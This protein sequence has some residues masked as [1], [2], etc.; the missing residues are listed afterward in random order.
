M[1]SSRE[2]MV[3]TTVTIPLALKKKIAENNVNLSKLVRDF[4]ANTIDDE[5]ST[6][7]TEAVLLNEKVRRSAPKGWDS[8]RV[9]KEWRKKNL[10]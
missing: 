5:E 1:A 10:S 7:M 9:I 6:N 4:L 2:K 3:R 8:T